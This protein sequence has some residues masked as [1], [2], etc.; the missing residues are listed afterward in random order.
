MLSART[1]TS[2]EETSVGDTIR[3]RHLAMALSRLPEHPQTNAADE[4]YSTEGDLAARWLSTIDGLENRRV[5]DLGAGNGVLGI[6]AHL[7]GASH[8]WLIEADSDAA[9]VARTASSSFPDV[10]VLVHRIDG[11]LP[12]EVQPET[13][14]MNPPWGWQTKA[15]DRPLL[16]AAMKSSADLIHLMHSAKATHIERLAE[17]HAWSANPTLEAEFRLPARYQHHVSR[18]SS[19]PVKCWRLSRD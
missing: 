19:T 7:L 3:Q 12:A 16:I 11:E 5:A 1:W 17:E 15:A 2:M 10:E 18:M 9:E 6:G 4:Q 13:V 14:I 8:V